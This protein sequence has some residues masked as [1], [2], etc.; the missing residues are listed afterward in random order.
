MDDTTTRTIILYVL[1]TEVLEVGLCQEI[2]KHEGSEVSRSTQLEKQQQMNQK[3]VFKK[4]L[5]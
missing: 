3:N 1:F 2:F 4:L 5:F